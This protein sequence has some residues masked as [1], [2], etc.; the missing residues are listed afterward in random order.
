MD[1]IDTHLKKDGYLHIKVINREEKEI[2]IS[3]RDKTI[4]REEKEINISPSDK[5]INRE[6]DGEIG[7]RDVK[8]Y[9]VLCFVSVIINIFIFRDFLVCVCIYVI[10]FVICFVLIMVIIIFMGYKYSDLSTDFIDTDLSTDFI[11]TDLNIKKIFMEEYKKQ[12]DILQHKG[13]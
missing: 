13:Y 7:G 11:D 2:N 9:K 4:N 6:I 12:Q 1:I 5:T 10:Y 8:I 3:P